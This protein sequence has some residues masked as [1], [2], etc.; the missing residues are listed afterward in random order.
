MTS[1]I[2]PTLPVFGDPTTASV[3][4]NFAIAASEISALQ[5]EVVVVSF[6][7]RQNAVVLQSSDVT[8]ALG[9]SPYNAANPAGFLTT[10]TLPIASTTTTGALKVDGITVTMSG[11]ILSATGVVSGVSS[12]NTRTGA[13][14]IQSSDVT[15][16]LGYTPYNAT[17]PSGYLTAGTLTP[18]II[19]TGLGYT[20]YNATNPAGYITVSSAPVTS[21]ATKTGAV[22][23][24]H[25]DISDW[26]ATLAAYAP[27]ASPTFT[28]TPAAP[29]ASVGTN[30]T[31]L[32]STAFVV[33]ALAAGAG[34]LKYS[35]RSSNTVLGVADSGSLIAFSGTFTQT[36]S[37]PATLGSVWACYLMNS[38]TGNI[39]LSPTSGTIDG[40]SSYVM[41][42]GEARLVQCDGTTLR[43]IIV[44]P[45]FV[46]FTATLAGGFVLPPGY[47]YIGGLMWS[48]GGSGGRDTT[49]GASG[50]GGGACMTLQI[51]VGQLSTTNNVVIGTGGAGVTTTSAAGNAGGNSSFGPA[52]VFG[53]GGG[54]INSVLG[55]LGGG[56]SNSATLTN[57]FGD[58]SFGAGQQNSGLL[59]GSIFG[60]GGGIGSDD[61]VGFTGFYSVYGGGGGGGFFASSGGIAAGG[62]SIFGGN[63][64]SGGSTASG[65]AGAVPAGG[66][67]G[68]QT[69]T[70][71]G[72]G[73]RGEL[74][75]WGIV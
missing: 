65:V 60:G 35:A 30:T 36:F 43:T 57:P 8:A 26:A 55:G 3:R 24:A 22:T 10:A 13:V 48:G 47:R 59:A 71:S 17:N 4:S 68:T 14:T 20:P 23:L 25:T 6:N 64:G 62:T 18:T 38:G 32:A 66:G 29:T 2:D 50:G 5:A 45:F 58:G 53:G 28:G 49:H 21:V 39:T 37:A 73:G 15:G 44:A 72:A 67:G 27:L 42:P 40:L 19:T 69:G 9:F 63:G 52:T 16:A 56:W 61:S 11:G 51:P 70:T 1:G 7:G 75:L 46:T 34:Q 54:N 33:A 31:Q 74:R 41:Y 12:V